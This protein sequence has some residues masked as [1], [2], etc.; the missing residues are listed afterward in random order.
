MSWQW[1]NN[2]TNAN[3]GEKVTLIV[4]ISFA[5]KNESRRE[6]DLPKHSSMAYFRD[7]VSVLQAARPIKASRIF[8]VVLKA[9]RP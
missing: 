9:N 3:K 6:R 2:H 7:V 8:V 4:Q 5:E 1:S